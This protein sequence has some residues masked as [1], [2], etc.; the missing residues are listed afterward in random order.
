M[1]HRRGVS[2]LL[3]LLAAA[4]ALAI[5]PPASAQNAY[6]ME[7]A[8]DGRIYVFVTQAQYDAWKASGEMGNKA[9]TR[10]DYGP[11]G[12]TVMFE[13]GDAIVAYN[14]KYQKSEAPPKDI[15]ADDVKLPFN[16]QYRMPGL[17]L[18]FPKAE[19]NL[20]N[21]LQVRFTDEQF[22]E[23]MAPPTPFPSTLED[24]GSFR[25]RRM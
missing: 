17:R 15:K 7:E 16:V 12:E 9:V 19:I 8:R 23:I 10:L 20:S 1:R 13:S 18:S 11:K 5:A 14:A 3:C 25:I 2:T 4:C 22:D 21:R 24:K 6:Y